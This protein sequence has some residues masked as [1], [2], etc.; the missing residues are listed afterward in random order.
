MDVAGRRP[1]IRIRVAVCLCQ[2]DQ[3][4]LVQHQKRG[5]RYWLLP[6]GGV[7]PGETMTAALERE[8]VEEAGLAIEVGR[9][10]LV[11]EVIEPEGRRHVVNMVFAGRVI[12]GELTVGRDGVLVDVRW[13][14][15]SALESLEMYPHITADVLRC[16]DEGFE[17]PL[18]FLGDVWRPKR[19]D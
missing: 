3:I 6:G 11:C 5:R 15:R 13:H 19:T 7:E 1:V 4:L 14:P 10:A 12:G 2:D 9:L 18:R 8:L 17:G 16:W